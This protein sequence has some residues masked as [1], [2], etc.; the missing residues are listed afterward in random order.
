MIDNI[1]ILL[2]SGSI[3]SSCIHNPL[4]EKC[5][6][7]I[8]T[9]PAHLSP[10]SITAMVTSCKIVSSNLMATIGSKY[11]KTKVRVVHLQPLQI[12]GGIN[13][14]EEIL[15]HPKISIHFLSLYI[16]DK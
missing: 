15:C 8:A 3:R 4:S 9:K 1:F 10:I 12:R 11:A 6:H 13:L 16:S 14:L 2:V 5:T 7:H